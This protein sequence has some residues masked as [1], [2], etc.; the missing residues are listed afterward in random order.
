[1]LKNL[2]LFLALL[3]LCSSAEAGDLLP[4]PAGLEPNV[5]FWT[6][7][8]SEV[9]EDGGLIHD[10]EH[11]DVVYEAIRFPSG[12]SRRGQE[13][14]TDSAKKRIKDALR[15][16]ARGKRT[17]LTPEQERILALWPKGTSNNP[18]IIDTLGES[19]ASRSAE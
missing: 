15:V 13:R 18:P 1:M 5:R 12:L 16:L 9:A 7:I 11:L 19:D 2:W 17:G 10:S 4:R 6:R 8:Y 3:A 14:R